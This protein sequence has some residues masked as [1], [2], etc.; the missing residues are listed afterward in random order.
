MHG[1]RAFTHFDDELFRVCLE[2]L[3][4]IT[5]VC[6]RVLGDLPPGD[7]LRQYIEGM[8]TAQMN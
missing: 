4:A 6:L 7:G 8:D 2:R 5:T 1:G 3:R